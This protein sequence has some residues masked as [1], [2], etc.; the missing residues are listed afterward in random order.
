MRNLYSTV[1]IANEVKQSNW[2]AAVIKNHSLAMTI[3]VVFKRGGDRGV[4]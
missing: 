4:K 2:I 3:G 1:V